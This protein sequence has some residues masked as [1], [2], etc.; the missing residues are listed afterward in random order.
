MAGEDPDYIKRLHDYEC[1]C[2]PCA[3]CDIQASHPRTVKSAPSGK[4]LGGR[5]GKGQR[6]DDK[7]AYPCCGRHHS[8]AQ[9]YEFA[10]P[11][12]YF[13]GWSKDKFAAWEAEQGIKFYGRYLEE[14]EAVAA[15]TAP[16][17]ATRAALRRKGFDPKDFAARW[18]AEHG[19]GEQLALDLGRD[20]K[21]ELKE[22]GVPL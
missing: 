7:D 20:L 21:R 10:K 4:R 11:N 5:P 6:S 15:G 1:A 13:Y 22:G 16:E 12:S 14:Q 3:S 17:E 18:C 8:Q 2:H 19:L 9:R